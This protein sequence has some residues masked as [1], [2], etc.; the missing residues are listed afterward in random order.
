MTKATYWQRGESLDYI[1]ETNEVIEANTIIALSE[2]IGVAG[3]SINP[4]EKG[5]IHVTGF[6]EIKKTGTDAI[7]QGAT[8]YWDGTGI[9]GVADNNTVAGYAAQNAGAGDM[10]VLVKLIG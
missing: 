1:N 5:S 9:T 7:A 4:G 6:Y 2:R 3:T 8:V 10:T